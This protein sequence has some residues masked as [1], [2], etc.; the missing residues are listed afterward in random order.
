MYENTSNLL[1]NLVQNQ[2]RS[3]VRQS[4]E[5][6]FEVISKSTSFRCTTKLRT[7]F[8]SRFKINVVS[9]YENT[10]NLLSKP[11]QNQRRSDVR[12]SLKSSFEADSKATSFRCTR[13]LRIVFQSRFKVNVVSE[14]KRQAG[15]CQGTKGTK[16]TGAGLLVLRL[17]DASRLA[18]RPPTNI[19][20]EM[21]E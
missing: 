17:R 19:R 5:S 14:I 1:S 12:Q 21:I 6:S 15:L 16:T 8:R 20:S 4:L 3:N 10:S 2:R 7:I 13:M 9:M 18:A 11:V